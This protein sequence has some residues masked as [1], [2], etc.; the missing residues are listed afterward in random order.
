MCPG[1]V[2]ISASSEEGGIVTN[3]MSYS[4][5]NGKMA[6]SGLLVDVRLSD[7][8]SDDVLAGI[9]FQ[10]KYERLAFENSPGGYEP[11]RAT[12]IGRASCRERV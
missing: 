1:G 9:E 2:V 6:N 8:E 4:R 7:F 5:R 11:P 10:R 12:Q 3:G